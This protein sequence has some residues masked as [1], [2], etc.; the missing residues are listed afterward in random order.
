MTGPADTG[1]DGF[2]GVSGP[3]QSDLMPTH[4]HAAAGPGPVLRRRVA[5]D[6]VLP[7]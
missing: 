2:E 1:I 6:F 5:Q 4:A 7:K 3:P